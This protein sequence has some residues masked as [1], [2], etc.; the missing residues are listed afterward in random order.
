MRLVVLAQVA[1]SASALRMPTTTAISRRTAISRGLFGGAAATATFAPSAARAIKVYADGNDE[2]CEAG[3]GAACDRIAGDNE[4]IK[5][6]QAQSKQNRAKN[7]RELYDK[8]VR[9]LQYSD[10]FDAM[11][12]NLVQLPN[13]S[14]VTFDMATYTK[15]RKEGRIQ[16]GA[17]DRLLPEGAQAQS[18]FLKAG[19]DPNFVCSRGLECRASADGTLDY[20]E[21]RSALNAKRVRAAGA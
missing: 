20:S 3:E 13:A 9:N 6:L 14:Y 4:L 21:F 8:T 15:L 17:V 11:D 7:E 18:D 5:R 10:Y 12:K 19:S 2:R 16:P 1:L